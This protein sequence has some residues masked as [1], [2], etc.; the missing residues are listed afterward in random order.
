MLIRTLSLAVPL[1]LLT[2]CANP[3]DIRPLASATTGVSAWTIYQSAG[4]AAASTLPVA[5]YLTASGTFLPYRPGST[6]VTYNPAVVPPGAAAELT[7]TKTG[8]G[9]EVRLTAG[10]LIPHRMYGAHLHT[11][12]CTAVPE[13]AGPHYQ[14]H[15]DP[16]ATPTSPS[17]NPI[18]ANAQNEIWLDFTASAAGD[19]SSS[20][21]HGWN[22][23]PQ[24]PPRS[25]V[26]HETH[27]MTASGEAGKAGAREACLTLPPA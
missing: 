20:V 7:I 11:K 25:L 13:E 12:P 23:D 6:A 14:N 18:Y 8:Y 1:T 26:L 9:S 16:A 17:A 21:S 27:T 15:K 24:S 4:P 22:F 3:I 5:P 10:G 19:A 2:A